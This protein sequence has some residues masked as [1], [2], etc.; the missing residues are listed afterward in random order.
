MSRL[1]EYVLPV[2]RSTRAQF[3]AAHAQPFLLLCEEKTETK[4]SWTFKTQTVSAISANVARL[5][6]QEDLKLSPELARYLVF[7]IAKGDNNPWPERVSL[8]RARNNDVVL[9]DTSVSKLHAHFKV[10]R[11]NEVFVSDAGSRNGTRVNGKA[12][13]PGEP[14]KVRVGDAI[15]FGRTT[16]TL[17]NAEELWEMVSRLVSENKTP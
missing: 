16:L 8:G 15:T 14:V 6:R 12:I 10:G 17:I 1:Y 4:K 11:K 7:P 3:V 13:D 5:A 9:G 2:R